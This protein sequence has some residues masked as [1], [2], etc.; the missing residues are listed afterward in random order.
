MQGRMTLEGLLCLAETGH[1]Q[2]TTTQLQ[3]L[4]VE[5]DPEERERLGSA[6]EAEGF[7]VDL[8]PGPSAPDYTCVGGRTGNCPLVHEADVIVFDTTIPGEDLFEGTPATALLALYIS[9]GRPVVTLVDRGWSESYVDHR[10]V[11]LERFPPVRELVHAVKHLM[12]GAPWSH[13]DD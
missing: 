2:Q 4:L 11:R 5:A 9:S 7:G 10:L 1:M 13:L 8:C 6:L 12:G 3:V